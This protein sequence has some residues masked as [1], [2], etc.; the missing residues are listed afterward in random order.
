MDDMREAL[1][2][3]AAS[4][5]P[6]VRNM[7]IRYRE[8]EQEF[9]QYQAFFSVYKL[10]ITVNGAAKRGP[11]NAPRAPVARTTPAPRRSNKEDTFA[12]AMQAL[13]IEHG[14]PMKLND[15]YSAYTEK[16]PE[17]AI[18]IETFRQ[19]LVKRREP[20]GPITLIPQRGYWWAGAELT[21]AVGDE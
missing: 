19:R 6:A 10:G 1:D 18:P 11:V 12:S 2:K 17:D 13:L 9:G 3:A 15:V 4:S 5:D 7:A 21:E 16:H 14:Q 8:M 20:S